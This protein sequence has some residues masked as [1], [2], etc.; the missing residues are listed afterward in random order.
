MPRD[1]VMHYSAMQFTDVLSLFLDLNHLYQFK[2]IR[3]KLSHPILSLH[4]VEPVSQFWP[5]C[6]FSLKTF[7]S[8]IKT[9]IFSLLLL[10]KR[11]GLGY[12]LFK[13]I[14]SLLLWKRIGLGYFLFNSITSGVSSDDAQ[15]STHPL[16]CLLWECRMYMYHLLKTWYYRIYV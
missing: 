10:W 4:R 2:S 15:L 11:I 9:L 5:W 14:S 3:E 8:Y 13:T 12:F 6:Q 1:T 16:P 7:F